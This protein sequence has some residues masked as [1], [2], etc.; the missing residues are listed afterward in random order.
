M[1]KNSTTLKDV[2]LLNLTSEQYVLKFAHEDIDKIFE[3]MALDLKMLEIYNLMDYSL[4]FVISFNPAYV[5]KFQDQFEKT[6]DN[7]LVKPYKLCDEER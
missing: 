6:K 2:N 3:Q 7:E 4:L 5:N 1:F